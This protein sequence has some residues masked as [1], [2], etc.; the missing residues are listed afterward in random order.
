MTNKIQIP[1]SKFQLR[2]ANLEA[3]SITNWETRI[4]DAGC[5][6]SVTGGHKKSPSCEGPLFAVW[7]SPE[8]V[9]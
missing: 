8:F 7:T 2:T 3:Y 6:G 4:P 5:P 1:N 9:K